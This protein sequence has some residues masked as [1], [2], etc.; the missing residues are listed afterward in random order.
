MVAGLICPSCRCKSVQ[1][2]K[3][4][5]VMYGLCQNCRHKWVVMGNVKRKEK[6]TC[7]A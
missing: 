1:T 4:G 5:A 6:Q 7:S 2:Y 3:A